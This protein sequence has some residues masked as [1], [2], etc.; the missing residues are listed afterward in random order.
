MFNRLNIGLV[1]NGLVNSGGMERYTLDILETMVSLG[2]KPTV[3]S[4]KVDWNLPIVN[5]INVVEIP[6]RF[7]PSRLQMFYVSRQLRKLRKT[8]EIDVML[9]CCRSRNV[10]IAICGGTHPGYM[11]SRKKEAGL[12]T[13]FAVLRRD[14]MRNRNSSWLILNCFAMKSLNIIQTVKTKCVCFTLR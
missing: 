9:G 7:I 13:L 14:H 6:C 12:I 1:C 2:I 11:E 4:K 8:F 5:S 3:F 10:D